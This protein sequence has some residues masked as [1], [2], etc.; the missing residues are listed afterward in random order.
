MQ[1]VSLFFSDKICNGWTERTYLFVRKKYMKIEYWLFCG[2]KSEL[3][4]LYQKSKKQ[5]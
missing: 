3:I 2:K 1:V 5:Y 4:E